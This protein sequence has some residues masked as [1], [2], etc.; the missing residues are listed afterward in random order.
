MKVRELLARVDRLAPFGLAERWDRVGLQVGELDADVGRLLVTL[1]PT[2]DA[3]AEAER[4]GAGALLSHHPLWFDPLVQVTDDKHPGDLVLRLAGGRR[5]LIAAHTNLDSTSGGLSDVLAEALGL[6]GTTPLAPAAVEWCKLVGFVPEGDADAVRAAIFAAGAGV[7]GGYVE[8]SFAIPG[9]GTFLGTEGTRPAV[10]VA[11]APQRTRE[12]RLEAVFPRAAR[13]AVLDA[14]AAAHPYEEPAFDVYPLEDEVRSVG[15]GRLGYLPEPA[16]LAQFARDVAGVFG[17]PAVRFTGDAHAH[18]QKIAVVPGSG[19][20]FIDVA[21]GAAEVLVT[22]DVKYH[23]AGRAGRLGL[24]LV[25]VPHE[26]SEGFAMERWARRLADD[27]AADGVEVVFHQPPRHLWTRVALDQVG[28]PEEGDEPAPGEP[29]DVRN[30]D[31]AHMH[32]YV[33]GGSRGNPGPAAIAGRL[34]SPGGELEEEFSDTIG[35]AT[36]NV[37]EYQAL[38][39]GLELALDHGVRKLTVFSDSELVVRQ[40]SGR[41]KV[42]DKVMESFHGQAL[43]LLGEFHEVEVRSI[44]REQNAAA[45]ALVN[46][47]LDRLQR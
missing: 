13:R 45:D 19:A 34:V 32:L 30:H 15:I 47:A 37:A 9:E 3:V 29:G 16:T 24:A 10:G 46:E 44:P 23:D 4:L 42:K 8:C 38:V 18:V 27:L 17:M 5:A 40:L 1:D 22:G 2:A 14:Y 21:A 41:Y 36:N 26:R 25:D 11:G 39:T 33:D 43:R 12:L 31:D 28:L 7:I 35:R 20:S 6:E